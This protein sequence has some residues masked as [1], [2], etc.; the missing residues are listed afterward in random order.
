VQKP[1]ARS[2]VVPADPNDPNSDLQADQL[3]NQPEEPSPSEI[4]TRTVQM[5]KSAFNASATQRWTHEREWIMCLAFSVGNH[6]LPWRDSSN[7]PEL[8]IDPDDPERTFFF[9]NIVGN[10]GLKKLKARLT[11]SKPTAYTKPRTTNQKDV[12][13]ADEGRD[14]L[15]HFD[16]IFDRQTQTQSMVDIML[17]TSTAFLK[18][19]FD[20]MAE[21]YVSYVDE[22]GG[23]ST[24]S[25]TLLSTSRS[26]TAR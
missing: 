5:V 1:Q 18:V 16:Q 10:M 22:T 3:E 4:E 23:S 21:D 9:T 7:Y 2:R 13:A 26:G 19:G 12:G 8:L 14:L 20:P 25:A 17:S 15:V 6:Y 11:M 24:Q